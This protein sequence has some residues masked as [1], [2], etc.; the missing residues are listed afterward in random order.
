MAAA[1]HAEDPRGKHFANI[2]LFNTPH[3]SL[4]AG[5]CYSLFYRLGSW[6]SEKLGSM[7]KMSQLVRDETQAGTQVY[8]QP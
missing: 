1:S 4:W 3:K 5:Y 2:I 8:L 6:G 7:S